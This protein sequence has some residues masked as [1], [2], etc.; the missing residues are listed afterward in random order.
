MYI[1]TG[2]LQ[3]NAHQPIRMDSLAQYK[4][5]HVEVRVF[6]IVVQ[7]WELPDTLEALDPRSSP[8]S[9][10]ASCLPPALLAELEEV[11]SVGGPSHLTGVRWILI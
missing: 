1:C 8:N 9:L 11:Q 5:K 4:H 6:C 2:H 10:A 3:P 7:E